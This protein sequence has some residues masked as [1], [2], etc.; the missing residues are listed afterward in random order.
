MCISE[1]EYRLVMQEELQKV[2]QWANEIVMVFNDVKFDHVQYIYNRLI[3][4]D[5]PQCL[6]FLRWGF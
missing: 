5:P 1:R 3:I 4:Q 6:S 2:Y